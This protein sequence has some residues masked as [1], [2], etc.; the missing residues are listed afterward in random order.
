[1]LSAFA[2]GPY[3]DAL[4]TDAAALFGDSVAY[5]DAAARRGGLTSVTT[6][7]T[8]TT[9]LAVSAGRL[10]PLLAWLG[11]WLSAEITAGRVTARRPLTDPA[12]TARELGAVTAERA[13]RLSHALGV[14]REAARAMPGPEPDFAGGVP[15]DDVDTVQAAFL[16]SQT[17]EFLAAA[18]QGGGVTS[19]G[20]LA[21]L[22]SVLAAAASRVAPLLTW[23]GDWLTAEITA[24]RVTGNRSPADLAAVA[25]GAHETA[26]GHAARLARALRAGN[27]LATALRHA[28]QPAG[29]AAAPGIRRHCIAR[30]GRTV[31]ARTRRRRRP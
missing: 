9:C 12:G 24:G 8:V 30:P 26:A 25:Q 17:A 11:E 16:G 2:D 21:G 28:G 13:S 27:Q 18:V 6:V 1:M 20:T 7:T 10:Q 22:I 29:P 14:A 23:L 19:L 5:L 31:S 3:D 15:Y 4:V